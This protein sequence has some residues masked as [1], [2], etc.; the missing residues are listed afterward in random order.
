MH[1]I[2]FLPAQYR[3]RDLHRKN[4]WSRVAVVLAFVGVFVAGWYGMRLNR[5]RV[6]R[7]LAAARQEYESATMQATE[8]AML[9]AQ[10]QALRSQADLVVYLRHPWSRA[11]L[12]RD[13][14]A[15]L[16]EAMSLQ[17]LRIS[18]SADVQGR[19]ASERVRPAR[20]QEMPKAEMHPAESDLGE[21]RR[22]IDGRPPSVLL[23]GLTTDHAVLH[24]YLAELS[25]LDLITHVELLGIDPQESN[26]AGYRFRVRL[27]ILPGYGQVGGPNQPPARANPRQGAGL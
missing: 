5:N 7:A 27:T 22:E 14:L 26:S 23:T 18:R 9:S 10:S 8:L 24:R 19:P 25:Q 11:R 15:P 6:E 20:E 1:G 21:L 16:P 2:D 3:E 12:V 17:E 13:V 4:R